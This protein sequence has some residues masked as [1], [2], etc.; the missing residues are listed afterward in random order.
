MAENMWFDT[1]RDFTERLVAVRSVS[2][3][4]DEIAV[5][6]TVIDLLSADGLA[7]VYEKCGLEPIS[8]DPYDR[9]N[10][11][12]YLPGERTEALILLGH[13]DT[14]GT[15]DYAAL[16]P[17]A[18]QATALSQHYDTLLGG[19]DLEHPE[20]WLFGRGALDMKSGVAANIAIMR[21]FAQR[22]R[23]TGQ[24]PPLS[25]ILVATPDEETQSAGVLAST[26]WLV[27]LRERAGL[28]YIGVINTDY[29]GP[30]FPGDEKRMIYTG[31]IGKMLPLFY[32]VGN[33]SHAGEPYAGVDANLISAELVRD[34]CM[35]LA[36][37]DTA[38]GES[39][40][41][42]VTLHMADLKTSYNVQTPFAAWFYLN[43]LTL[44]TTPG[45][46]LQRFK[47]QAQLSLQAVLTRLGQRYHAYFGT[48]DQALPSH[49]ASGMVY[50]YAELRAEVM[51]TMGADH[52]Q[53]TLDAVRSE[54]PASM[55]SR[56]ATLHLLTKLWQMSG[57]TGP[58]VVI[59]L[60][61]PYYPHV[62]NN[63]GLLDDA[64]HAVVARHADA[65][66]AIG[67][68]FPL[69][70]D[71]S[72]MRIDPALDLD[73]LVSTMPLWSDEP[74]SAN[75]A[76]YS[77]PF[78]TIKGMAIE[79]VVD[80]GPYGLDGHQRGERVH[81]PYSFEMVPRMILETITEV[82]E[83]MKRV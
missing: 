60:A 27:A 62:T 54:C 67:H 45:D 33:A 30:R 44:T 42:P 53:A 23:D 7:D 35:N 40:P 46:L 38:R 66:V 29:V 37:S 39:T 34:L 12:A 41:P 73:A 56:E 59:A 10:A 49:L 47:A 9:A 25:L 50:T 5:A 72:Y 31:S 6:E 58:A 75:A 32:V 28:R 4:R 16:E 21:H 24:R 57:K 55:D 14:V 76:G 71:L 83:R 20:D 61:P 3:S 19:R 82:A 70:S 26:A 13:I 1:V 2:P 77:L 22:Q 69:L 18:T 80:I 43:V 15:T 63:G 64:V 51:R 74:T 52:V 48:V 11:I 68:Y 36:F 81:M 65:Q 78:A 17:L 8:D 79:G